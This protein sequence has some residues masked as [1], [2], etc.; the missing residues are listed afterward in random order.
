MLRALNPI[1]ILLAVIVLLR[2]VITFN[3]GLLAAETAVLNHRISE[4][5]CGCTI[6]FQAD[7]ES[8]DH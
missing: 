3:V 2:T 6:G 1:Q 7:A 4:A 8:F 5:F